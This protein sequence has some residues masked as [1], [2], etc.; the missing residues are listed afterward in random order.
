MVI[1]LTGM[2]FH[3]IS[4]RDATHRI[5]LRP[6]EI[7]LNAHLMQ[8]LGCEIRCLLSF[9]WR[10]RRRNRVGIDLGRKPF[11]KPL[12]SLFRRDPFAPET[13]CIEPDSGS[14]RGFGTVD[15][16][17]DERRNMRARIMAPAR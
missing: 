1:V 10:S 13:G 11:E 7:T 6:F 2:A 16:P 14:G 5:T 3:E 17:P 9:A 8:L 15:D 12:E 4:I